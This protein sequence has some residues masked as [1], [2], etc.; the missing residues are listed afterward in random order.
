MPQLLE[1]SFEMGSDSLASELKQWV[2]LVVSSCADHLPMES[3]LAAA[4]VLTRTAPLLLTSPRLVLDLQDTLTL[5]RCVLT[6]LQSEEQAVRDAATETVTTA[7]SQGNTC[8]A[9]ALISTPPVSTEFAF[10]QVD[11]SVALALALAVL[12][13]LLQQWD[14]LACGL[15]I[16]LGWLLG[17]GDDLVGCVQ[18]KHQA[19]Q[20][21]LFE[22]AEVNFWAETLTFVSHLRRELLCLLSKP[23]QQRLPSSKSLCP[24]QRTATQQRHRL[25]ALF[26][27]L[28]P[29]A[30]F[31]RTVEW[32]RLRVQEERT[33]AG[34]GLLAFLEEQHGPGAEG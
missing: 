32:T 27:E 9:T 25:T 29:T 28:P 30:E 17:E 7:M 18:S 21:D 34:L 22:K 31:L 1:K 14:Q 24:L 26:G 10:C 4:D 12:C 20:E 33:L 8:Q 2:Q 6:L 19:A 15:P 3:R 13:D 5:W 23:G 16:L 11:A